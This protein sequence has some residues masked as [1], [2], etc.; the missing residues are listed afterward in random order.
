MINTRSIVA[1]LAAATLS[2]TLVIASAGAAS[3]EARVTVANADGQATASPSGQTELTVTGTGF[4]SIQNGFGGIYVMFG[5]VDASGSWRPSAGGV[6]GV[7]YRYAADDEQKPVGFQRF[8]AFPGSSTAAEASGVLNG[9]G[10]WTTT[11]TTPGAEF[12]SLDRNRVETK[13]DCL[14]VQ[15]GVI[16][17]G[18][19]GVANANNETFTPV[20]FATPSSSP[21][22]APSATANSGARSTPADEQ[23]PGL[24]AVGIGIVLA[25]VIVL[26]VLVV[27]VL[28]RRRAV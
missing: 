22:P 26:T 12:T 7:D 16:T 25:V 3:A 15:C 2:A 6:T 24:P 8:L 5:W 17:I 23:A 18:A 14:T 27:V 20:S 4:Q 10:S 11:I 19:H 28:R 9:D 13:V 21:S 1:A